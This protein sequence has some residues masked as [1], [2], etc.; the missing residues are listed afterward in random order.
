MKGAELGNQ[1]R[2]RYEGFINSLRGQNEKLSQIIGNH[3]HTIKHH[4]EVIG[5]KQI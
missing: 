1:E 3:S 4:K 2:E 5:N